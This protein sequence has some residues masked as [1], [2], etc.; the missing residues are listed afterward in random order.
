VLLVVG[1][2][3]SLSQPVACMVRIASAPKTVFVV[4]VVSVA[5]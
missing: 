5:R 3:G 1:G 2:A 4:L